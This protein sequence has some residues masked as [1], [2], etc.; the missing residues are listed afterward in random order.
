MIFST[1]KEMLINPHTPVAQKV[2][3]EVVFQRFQ[4][5][6]V[7]FFFKSDLTTPFPLRFLMRRWFYSLFERMRLKTKHDVY[8]LRPTS[9]HISLYKK[10]FLYFV[11]L[12]MSPG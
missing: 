10:R 3:Y 5:E 6:G 8:S 7:Q 12:A 11:G 4:D 9:Y 1:F 2:A